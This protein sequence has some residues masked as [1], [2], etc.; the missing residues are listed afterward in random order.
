[1]SKNRNRDSL[2]EKKRKDQVAKKEGRGLVIKREGT[3]TDHHII[4]VSR[5]GADE[6]FNK[7]RVL[8]YF[9]KR[10]HWLFGEM[11]PDEMLAFLETYFWKGE[12]KFI[13]D[14]VKNRKKTSKKDVVPK[15]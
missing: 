8:D 13:D 1:M 14:F 10:L 12:T 4:P 7:S 2:P 6:D 5:D 11:T 15:K 3:M 9:H